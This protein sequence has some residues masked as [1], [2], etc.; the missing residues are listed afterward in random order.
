[1]ARRVERSTSQNSQQS[2][3][4]KGAS[5]A[6][7]YYPSYRN[8]TLSFARKKVSPSTLVM[9]PLTPHSSLES[10]LGKRHA[11]SAYLSSNLCREQY[12]RKQTLSGSSHRN[13]ST[14]YPD[15]DKI[16][17]SDAT[18]VDPDST[19]AKRRQYATQPKGKKD[20]LPRELRKYFMFKSQ[21][22]TWR[23]VRLMRE[24]KSYLASDVPIAPEYKILWCED[25]RSRSKIE[26][27]IQLDDDSNDNW[28]MSSMTT[29]NTL[30][31]PS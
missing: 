15:A 28:F 17:L 16:R 3:R 14:C 6:V 24:I 22:Y 26:Q 8:D 4:T 12:S 11:Y 23:R 13:C 25:V 18:G 1:M 27:D 10:A 5:Q 7:R 29:T 31:T 20:P 9:S 30:S 2:N 21:S 19:L